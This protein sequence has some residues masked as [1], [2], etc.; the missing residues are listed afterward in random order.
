M[1]RA[2]GSNC[3]FVFFVSLSKENSKRRGKYSKYY[4]D[5]LDF[6]WMECHF[7]LLLKIPL[8]QIQPNSPH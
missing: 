3:V 2:A 7:Y 4:K 1:T 8:G 5:R 6:E